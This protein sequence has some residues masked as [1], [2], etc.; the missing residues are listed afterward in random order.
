MSRRGEKGI[1]TQPELMMWQKIQASVPCPLNMLKELRMAFIQ[2][3]KSRGRSEMS[4]NLFPSIIVFS[5]DKASSL[6]LS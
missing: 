6:P 2:I 5:M 1:G 3:A 4:F